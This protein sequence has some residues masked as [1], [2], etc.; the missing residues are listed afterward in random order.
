MEPK[1]VPAHI[2]SLSLNQFALHLKMFCRFGLKNI[3]N[4]CAL[5]KIDMTF[6]KEYISGTLDTEQG[7]KSGYSS[8]KFQTIKF[9]A[10][11]IPLVSSMLHR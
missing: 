5:S 2:Q 8:F 1:D 10:T 4:Y 11:I 6:L 9:H 7:C 3:E